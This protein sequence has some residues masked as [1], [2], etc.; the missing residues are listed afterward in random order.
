M[1]GRGQGF[2]LCIYD[3]ASF[4]A[5]IKTVASRE[6]SLADAITGYDSEMIQRGIREARVANQISKATHNWELLSQFP[7]FKD[8]LKKG[9][10][11]GSCFEV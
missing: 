4:V 10:P 3:A 8:G 5:A 7:L 2:Q 6:Q 1:T 11:R 9:E